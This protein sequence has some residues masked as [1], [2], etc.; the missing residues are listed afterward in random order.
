MDREENIAN[1]AKKI[2]NNGVRKDVCDIIRCIMASPVSSKYEGECVEVDGVRPLDKFKNKPLDVQTM[3]LLGVTSK[4]L[5]ETDLKCVELLLKYGG[6][7]PPKQQQVS[8]DLPEFID[9]IELRASMSASAPAMI[10]A[11]TEKDEEDE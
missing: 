2:R 4:A 11:I 1:T 5:K 8:I 9:G 6:Y 3:M 7:E 10:G